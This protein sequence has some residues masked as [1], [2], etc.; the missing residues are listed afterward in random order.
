MVKLTWKTVL[1]LELGWRLRT[2]RDQ[3]ETK[4]RKGIFKTGSFCS[5]LGLKVELNFPSMGNGTFIQHIFGEH[6]VYVRP[7]GAVWSL[8]SEELKAEW[9]TQACNQTQ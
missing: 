2:L 6:P 4:A 5:R 8:P 3:W 9:R 1:S 7:E